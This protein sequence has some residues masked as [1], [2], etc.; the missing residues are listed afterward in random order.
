MPTAP[1]SRCVQA[2]QL[3][4]FAL[5]QTAKGKC[6]LHLNDAKVIDA[7]VVIKLDH[8]RHLAGFNLASAGREPNSSPI[9]LS[10]GILLVIFVGCME[11]DYAKR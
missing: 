8:F 9:D 4:F 7:E 10:L 5:E 11:G 3:A 1:P 6:L 2:P